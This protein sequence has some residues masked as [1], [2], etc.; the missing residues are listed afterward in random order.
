MK[1]VLCL[2]EVV[3]AHRKVVEISE[4]SL[5]V[6]THKISSLTYL[7]LQVVAVV[8]AKDKIYKPRQ[9]L[10]SANQYLEQ[11]LICV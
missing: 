5:V 4:T 3:S 9:Q 7:A 11:P 2:H 1:P 10:L 8:P 6:E